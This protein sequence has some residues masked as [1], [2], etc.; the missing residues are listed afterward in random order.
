MMGNGRKEPYSGQGASCA[1]V[2]MKFALVVLVA[3]GLTM[4]W[5]AAVVADNNQQETALNVTADPASTAG[6]VQSGH[7]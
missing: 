2:E 6:A 3:L 5:Q 4:A 1:E 7:D